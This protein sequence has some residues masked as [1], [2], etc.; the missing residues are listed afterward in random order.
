MKNKVYYG[1]YTLKH[2]S[3]TYDI[4]NGGEITKNVRIKGNGY[5]FL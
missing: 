3:H 4:K 2:C 1:E 5:A